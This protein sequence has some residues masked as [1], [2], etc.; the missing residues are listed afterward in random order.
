[1]VATDYVCAVEDG[2]T[3][4]AKVSDP[5]GASSSCNQHGSSLPA[6]LSPRNDDDARNSAR[7]AGN[8]EQSQA[9]RLLDEELVELERLILLQRRKVEALER[10][11]EQYIS[12]QRYD[13]SNR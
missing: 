10:L 7:A 12:G 2:H 6:S 13:R 5:A 9:V 1:M 4:H 8:L 11:R 3:D